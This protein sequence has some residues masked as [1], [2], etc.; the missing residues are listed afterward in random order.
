MDGMTT[1][2]PFPTNPDRPPGDAA[3]A[4]GGGPEA[5]GTAAPLVYHTIFRQT[6][7]KPVLSDLSARV[8]REHVE[9]QA[10]NPVAGVRMYRRDWVVE[11]KTREDY[12]ERDR[13]DRGAIT[14]FSLRSRNRLLFWCKNCN[15]D[16]RSMATLTYPA[17]YPADGPTVKEHLERVIHDFLQRKFRARGIWFLEFQKRG[18]P[19]FHLLLTTDLESLGEIVTKKR[20]RLVKSNTTFEYRTNIEAERRLSEEWFRIVGSGD[21]KHLRAGVQWEC[22]ESS[23]AAIRYAAKHAAKPHQKVVPREFERVGRFWGKFGKVALVGGEECHEFSTEQLAKIVGPSCVSSRGRIKKYLYDAQTEV[24]RTGEQ[25][26]VLRCVPCGNAT[27]QW[28]VGDIEAGECVCRDCWPEF[29]VKHPFI[30][31]GAT[32]P[33]PSR[34][35]WR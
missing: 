24:H 35:A 14:K 1:D 10:D 23:D 6:A 33:E 2:R 19:H 7:F 15:C 13:T 3:G 32:G 11:K 27:D 25:N 8:V 30:R 21:E 31:S 5:A 22:L 29:S 16:F 34:F 28:T 9:R 18:A 20:T 12:L 4:P 17:E 26:P